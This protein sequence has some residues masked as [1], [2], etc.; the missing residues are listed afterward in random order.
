M[1]IKERKLKG[2]YELLLN[3]HVDARGFFMR[4]YDINVFLQAGLSCDWVQENQSRS[5][6]RGTI[7][8]LHIQLPPFTEAKLVRCIRGA[9]LDVFVDLR[10]GSDTFGQFDSLELSNKNKKIIYIPKGFAHGYCTLTNTS[11]VLYKVDNFYS[12]EHE[13]GLLW[14]DPDLDIHWPLTNP[15][16]SDKDRDNITFKEFIAI[17]N[18]VKLDNTY[19]NGK[20]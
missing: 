15:I 8:G 16:I 18:Y 3:P 6:K 5:L 12:K 17:F 2:V 20:S 9:I 7:R 13:V 10:Q 14:N 4:T 19:N 1:E 11:E